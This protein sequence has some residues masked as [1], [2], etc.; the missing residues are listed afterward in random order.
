MGRSTMTWT[1]LALACGVTVPVGA[2]QAVL[3]T[4]GATPVFNSGGFESDTVGTAPFAATPNTGVPATSAEWEF[5]GNR[6]EVLTGATAGGPAGAYSGSNYAT[7]ERFVT[8]GSP[9]FLNASFSQ[10]LNVAT[11]SFSI[12]TMVWLG[13]TNGGTAAGA[14]RQAVFLIM[15]D[16]SASESPAVTGS[17]S[18][19]A[20]NPYASNL[21]AGF[22]LRFKA[23][24]TPELARYN[25]SGSQAAPGVSTT[26]IPTASGNWTPGAWNAITYA[27]D[28]AQAKSFLTV[29]GQ[30]PIDITMS[31][32]IYIAAPAVVGQFQTR[33]NTAGP[34]FLDAVPEPAALG[35]LAAAVALLAR[36]RRA[37]SV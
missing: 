4:S 30:A 15:P 5:T 31:A 37:A 26:A 19:S 8:G 7:V 22:A 1:A 35:A 36:R 16:S 13:T 34:L 27:W 3:I 11:D 28:A 2:A 18:A 6:T 10:G 14:N 20:A 9:T 23:D 21:L 25:Y 32:P 29:N 17:G 24:Q 12:S 33:A